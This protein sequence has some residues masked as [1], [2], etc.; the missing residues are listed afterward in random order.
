M[1]LALPFM[2]G[3]EIVGSV[4]NVGEAVTNFKVGDVIYGM[5]K[6]GGFAEYV[7]AKVSDIALKPKDLDSKHAAAIPL[8]GLTAWQ[9]IFDLGNLSEGQQILITGRLGC[10]WLFS[11]AVCQSKRRLRHRSSFWKK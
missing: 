6:A 11:G 5:V 8:G 9:S 10:S 3:G 1:G 4:E 7:V 2:L